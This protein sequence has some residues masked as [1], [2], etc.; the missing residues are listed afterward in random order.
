[1]IR[2]LSEDEIA[3]AALLA[4][5]AFQEDPGFSHILPADADRRKRLPSLLDAMFRVDAASGGRV[6]GA[7]DDCALIGIVATVPVRAPH[8]G[9]LDW[10]KHW[11]SLSWMA[12][13]PS[14]ILR[15][16][17][18]SDAVERLRPASADYLHV[19][20]VHPAAQGRGVGAALVREVLKDG[21]SVYLETFTPKNVAWYEARGFARAAEVASPVRPP[22]WTFI[23]RG[24]ALTR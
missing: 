21:S 3:P 16:L 13:S 8:R 23:R 1:V 5:A 10:L 17:A 11:R 24:S 12:A 22:F 15:A 9:V 18:L 4:A 7:F 6:R 2:E 14:T 20:A 19:L